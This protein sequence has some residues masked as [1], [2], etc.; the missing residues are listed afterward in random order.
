[1]EAIDEM[2]SSSYSTSIKNSSVL[3]QSFLRA[4]FSEFHWSGLEE[5]TFQ[6]IYSQN[7][8]LC[9]M[10]GLPYPTMSES[11]AVCSSRW[12]HGSVSE[13]MV[14][15]ELRVLHLHLKASRRILVSR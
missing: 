3:E 15:E 7:L 2:F 5:A 12:E 11:M 4:I 9:R 6:Q 14:L 1:M 13:V 8:A 10:E